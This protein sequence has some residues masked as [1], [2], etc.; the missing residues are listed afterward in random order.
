MQRCNNLLKELEN[1]RNYARD[2][3]QESRV[4]LRHFNSSVRTEAKSL[5]KVCRRTIDMENPQ[6]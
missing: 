4:E 6:S 1:F 2:K 5:A 3:K